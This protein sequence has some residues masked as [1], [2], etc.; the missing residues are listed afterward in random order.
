MEP[1]ILIAQIFGLLVTLICLISP[2]FKKNWQMAL[3][4]I[5]ANS[6]SALNFLLLGEPSA[7][8]VCAAAVIQAIVAIYHT[9]NGSKPGAVE[10][11]LFGVLYVVGGLLP[12]LVSGTLASFT[13]LDVLPIF[14]ALLYLGYL[15]EKREQRM[16][17]FSLSNA[18]LFLVYDILVQS[19]H[20]FAQLI[21]IISIIIAL[22]RYRKKETEME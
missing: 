3:M 5:L 21:S 7:C 20:G 8:G 22:I 2:Q 15:A 14:G 10:L 19:T 9:K 6:C 4:A 1:K 16:R 18:A 17:L 13:W 12:F 11:S